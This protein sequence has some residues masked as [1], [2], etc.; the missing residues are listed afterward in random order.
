MQ[1]TSIS[2]IQGSLM[3]SPDLTRLKSETQLFVVLAVADEL[4]YKEREKSIRN[5]FLIQLNFT[6]ASLLF[7]YIM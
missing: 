2:S 1:N 7:I 6:I 4:F 3:V 5:S